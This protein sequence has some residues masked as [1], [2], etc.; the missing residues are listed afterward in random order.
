MRRPL[1]LVRGEPR[2]PKCKRVMIADGFIY[3][4][5]P[6]DNTNH[7][8][9]DKS[10]GRGGQQQAATTADEQ[11]VGTQQKGAKEQQKANGKATT[12]AQQ[13]QG[14][15]GPSGE[16]QHR[17]TAGCARKT[18][19]TRRQGGYTREA[20]KN[21]L[22]GVGKQRPPLLW[23]H[24]EAVVFPETQKIRQ[25]CARL[26]SGA[27]NRLSTVRRQTFCSKISKYHTQSRSQVLASR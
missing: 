16:A 2:G 5:A 9:E 12:T 23:F 13:K 27:P 22:G 11:R 3:L 14:E 8:T 1:R 17:T 18:D 21:G 15:R 24:F 10:G 25:S 26:L 7:E 6:P 4:T 20:G 19:R